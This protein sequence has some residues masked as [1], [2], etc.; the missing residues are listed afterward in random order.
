MQICH[1]DLGFGLPRGDLS[2]W[3][4]SGAGRRKKASHAVANVDDG[5]TAAWER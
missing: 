1:T 3:Q 5:A 2:G 4:V